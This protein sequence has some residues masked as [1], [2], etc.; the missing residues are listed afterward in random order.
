MTPSHPHHSTTLHGRF[1]RLPATHAKVQTLGESTRRQASVGDRTLPPLREFLNATSTPPSVYP[2][3]AQSVSDPTPERHASTVHTYK[4]GQ[5]S[6]DLSVYELPT[7]TFMWPRLNLNAARPP[8]SDRVIFVRY[9]EK[10]SGALRDEGRSAGSSPNMSGNEALWSD[11]SNATPGT[12]PPSTP[13]LQLRG[14]SPVGVEDAPLSPSDRLLMHPR[15]SRHSSRAE[16]RARCSPVPPAHTRYASREGGPRPHG[17]SKTPVGTSVAPVD[18]GIVAQDERAT[19]LAT[20]SAPPCA[21]SSSSQK[22]PPTPPSTGRKAFIEGRIEE[23]RQAGKPFYKKLPHT[24]PGKYLEFARRIPKHQVVDGKDWACLLE[25]TQKDGSRR[26][27][28]YTGK[29]HLVKRHI[30]SLHLQLR[31]WECQICGSAASQKTNLLTH[32]NTHTG[33][34]PHV[35]KLCD[36]V[37]AFKDPAR[38]CRHKKAAHGYLTRRDRELLKE[39][40]DDNDLLTPHAGGIL[41]DTDGDGEGPID[42]VALLNE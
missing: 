8:P 22:T 6:P 3:P 42:I 25:A 30:E 28:K 23:L 18:G 1:S 17:C 11:S 2:L 37:S 16:A 31:L 9:G 14:C 39:W 34:T 7:G 35:C 33:E 27:C 12:T 21:A 32:I 19:R 13:L 29:K 4:P 40:A 26:P 15:P 41:E 20:A 10:Q 24:C 5:A 36:P 38:Y